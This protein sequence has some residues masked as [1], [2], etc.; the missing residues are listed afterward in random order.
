M[1]YIYD[2][3]KKFEARHADHLSVYGS[4]NQLRL[5]G[6]H[7]TS[8]ME[9][10]SFG[11]GDRAASFRIPTGTM[12]DKGKGYIEDRRPASNM[13]PYLVCGMMFDTS[14]LETSLSAPMM[15][16]Y[17]KWS[18]QNKANGDPCFL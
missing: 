4:D 18:A 6:H 15:E 10:F 2:M 5:T 9:K 11:C 1:D 8:S 7:E 12:A 16:H 13:D 14:V 17:K 3:L